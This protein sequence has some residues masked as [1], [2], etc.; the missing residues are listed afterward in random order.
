MLIL[1]FTLF[2]LALGS[3]VLKNL[4]VLVDEDINDVQKLNGRWSLDGIL[5]QTPL[6]QL[7]EDRVDDTALVVL[8]LVIS[9]LVDSACVDVCLD[10]IWR[11]SIKGIPL[12]HK[13]VQTASKRPHVNLVGHDA[14]VAVY[15]D[16][17]RRVVEVTAEVLVLHQLLEVV[18]HSNHVDFDEAL[19][20]VDAGGVHVSEDEVLVVNVV[21][22]FDE[23]SKD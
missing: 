20:E 19:A 9:R 13:V 18:G 22:S 12:G 10:D 1:T 11:A 17:R 14:F 16:L 2:G 21:D 15:Q 3:L 7:L 5:A 4:A 6:Q 23:L 8:N